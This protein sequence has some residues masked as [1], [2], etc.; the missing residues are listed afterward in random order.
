[1]VG[2]L[3]V[4]RL[5]VCRLVFAQLVVSRLVFAQLVGS[6]L[7]FAQLVVSWLV[8]AQLVVSRLIFAQ[9][10]FSRLVFAQLL[11]SR[12]VF[13]QLVVSRLGV[14]RLVWWLI[15]CYPAEIRLFGL[16]LVSR[17]LVVF[18]SRLLA[19]WLL[20]L[21]DL[22]ICTQNLIIVYFLLDQ[23]L[24]NSH[25]ELN[26]TCT[27]KKKITKAKNFSFSFLHGQILRESFLKH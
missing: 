25:W 2:W 4:A 13:A 18:F 27:S 7:V 26:L 19:G 15:G 9:L 1:M 14:A 17:S 5:V 21:L 23:L 11:V 20:V 3:G 16:Y 24:V 10:V 22:L 12:L 8:F 6:R